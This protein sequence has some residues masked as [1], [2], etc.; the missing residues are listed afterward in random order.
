MDAYM[1]PF[2]AATPGSAIRAFAD[3]VNNVNGPMWKHADDYALF[4]LGE[5]NE[6]TGHIEPTKAPEQLAL[7][8]Q[9]RLDT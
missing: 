7:A 1:P 6:N 5:F 8:K 3:E 2:V 4:K 9:L